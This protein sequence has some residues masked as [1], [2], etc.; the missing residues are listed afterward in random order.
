[1]LS[2]VT[3]MLARD[4]NFIKFLKLNL[5]IQI[6]MPHYSMDITTPVVNTGFTLRYKHK[7]TFSQLFWICC[8]INFALLHPSS[9]YVVSM[10]DNF[11]V[12]PSIAVMSCL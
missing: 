6:F 11:H 5:G 3:V 10:S 1:M 8:E 12:C 2:F 7:N 9:S 4:L